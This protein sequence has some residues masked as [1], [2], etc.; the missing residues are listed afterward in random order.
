M[1]TSA[2]S[3]RKG[4]E[5]AL[6]QIEEAIKRP[7]TDAAG[8]DAA[9][10]LISNLQDLLSR[11]QGQ[12]APSE[13]EEIS[14][15][16]D[17]SHTR[18]PPQ[19]ATAGD[20][21]ALDD[22]ENPL[23]LL[24]RASDLQFSPAECSNAP[25]LSPSSVSQPS[26]R[27]DSSHN[28]D[29]PNVR[30]FFV[31][32]RANLDLGPDMD[33][34]ELG[35]TTL[36]EAE[37]L[38]SFFY[39][40][41]AHTRWGLDPTVHTASFVRSQSAFLFTSILA[42]A[43]RFNPSAAALSK[44]LTRHCTS[45]AHKVIAQR[46]RSVEIVLAFM[47]NIPWMTPG[48]SSGDD[49]TCS[50][51]AMALT[52]ALDLSLNKIVTPPT[53]FDST[54]QNRLAK[55]DCIDAKRALHMDG[56]EAVDPA[57]EWGRRLLR[58]RERTWI[59]L[60]VLERGVCLARGRSY[61]VPPTALV[62]NC[63]RWHI[64]DIADSRDGSMNSMAVLRR[65]LDELLKK[66]KSRCDNCRLGDTG[67]EAAQSIKKLIEDFYDQWYAAW[68]LEIGGPSPLEVKRFFRAAGLSSALNVMRA[69]IQGESRLKSMPNNTVIMIAFAACSALSL[70]VM[71]ADSRSSLAPSVRHLIEETADVLERIGATPAHREGASV[72]Y[73]RLLRELVRRAHVGSTSQK[74]TEAVPV[75]SLQPSS[76]LNDY[77]P[78]PSVTQPPM[79]PATLWPETLQF[80]AMSDHQ[81][82]DAV[83]RA[84]SAFGMNIPDVPLDDLMNWD[85]FD[86]A[87]AADLVPIVLCAANNVERGYGDVG[88]GLL[89]V[90]RSS[91][92]CRMTLAPK[93]E[94]GASKL[95]KDAD[96]AVADLKSGSTIL[97]SGFGL[98]GVADTL[99]SAINRRGVEN[100]HSL[101]AVSNN[102]GAPGRGGLSTLTQAGQVNRLILSY[103]GNNKALEK[104]YLTGKIAIE[105]CPQGT[106]A[107]RLRAGGAG[108]PAFF[109]PTGAHTLLQAGEIPIRLD[110]SGKALERG[111]PR[112]TR[113][114]NGKTYLMET[115]LTGDVAILRA[116]KAD[117]AGNCVFRY[118][119]KAFGPIMAK[120]ATL[121]IVEAENIVPVGSIDPNDV[122]LPGIFV[123]RVIPATAE[124]HIEIKKLRSPENED[125]G[126][127]S[128]DP[129]MVQRNRIARR[130]AKELKQGYYVNLG[131][132]I[133]TLAPSF[134]PEGVKVWVQSEN[135]ILGMG[136]YPTEDEVDPDIINAGKETVT[137]MPGAATFDS[138][139][140]FGMIRGGHVDVS[141]LGALQVSAKGDLANYMIPGKVFKGMGGAM[142]LISNPDQTK[143]VVA[144]SHTAKDGSPKIV[145]EC[146]LP[147]TGAN[148]V[149]TII[150][151]L[152]VFQV[153][154]SKGELLLTEL[155]PGVEVE[156][157]RSKTGAKFAVAEQ[158]EIM[159]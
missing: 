81:I 122:D 134:L 72:L 117:E 100:L 25:K 102:A 105:L 44:R 64:S 111:T 130:A 66:V 91:S 153:N 41:L 86:F 93:I 56:F 16:P 151:D 125:A 83:N 35:L 9:R 127:S 43:A 115:A 45:L 74:N 131:V 126:K 138:T 73:G 144:T 150:T 67:S 145:A 147:L 155:A 20:N 128:S 70:S 21:L 95:F 140:S 63:D 99:I 75:E 6:H 107:E 53:G 156:E 4:L 90:P 98:C 46:H 38:F 133:P 123:D 11:T 40:N 36:L 58:R 85:W 146:S 57:S 78:V 65:N 77:C 68:A 136:P 154:R 141:I 124:K 92:D 137:L 60:F 14:D 143:I 15:D 132:G 33:P 30:S 26:I 114:F 112:E 7:K 37:S 139:E 148:C 152:C 54:L 8:S 159:E 94:R 82:I 104:K 10:K 28:E 59:A 1:L 18:S 51:I 158:L 31:P 2:C 157:V 101:T 50:Y 22:A 42:A 3:K 55:A 87:N 32:V 23:Q 118:T 29:V 5:K 19:D 121:T 89:S 49:D 103:L 76:T 13:V 149:S 110:E 24:A 96:E 71:P 106:L 27:L 79:D 62:E 80:S 47:V 17:Q 48:N 39:E 84:D 135:G 88:L 61:T 69:A 52:V 12:S 108:I 120:A 129:A 119:T 116:W 97:S 113:I 34:I 142:D 109:T